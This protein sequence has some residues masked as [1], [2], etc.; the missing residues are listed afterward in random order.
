MLK[1]EFMGLPGRLITSVGP[2]ACECLEV[3]SVVKS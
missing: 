1:Q 2:K 3:L